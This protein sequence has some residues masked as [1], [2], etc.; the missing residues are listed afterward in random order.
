[1]PFMSFSCRPMSGGGYTRFDEFT[2]FF[3]DL[4]FASKSKHVRTF[5]RVQ[6]LMLREMREIHRGPTLYITTTN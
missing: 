5:Q 1:M 2:S 3:I 6:C 4:E